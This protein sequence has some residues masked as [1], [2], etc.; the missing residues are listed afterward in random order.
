M[1]LMYVQEYS[2]DKTV[3]IMGVTCATVR[4]HRDRARLRIARDLN[5]DP[6]PDRVNE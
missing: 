5:L 3:R 1:V 6:A 2:M 4:S